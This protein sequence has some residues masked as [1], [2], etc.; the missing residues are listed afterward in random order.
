MAFDPERGDRAA[1]AAS[2]ADEGER[3]AA[4]LR[5]RPPRRAQRTAGGDLPAARAEAGPAAAGASRARSRSRSRRCRRAPPAR[6]G[7]D[8]PAARR[9]RRLPAAP[10]DQRPRLLRRRARASARSKWC[11]STRRAADRRQLHHR[12]SSS[13][14]ACSLTPPLARGLL[15]GV[16]R[17]ELID[18]G[19]AVERD[20]D[21]R[22]S[23]RRLPG[24]QCAARADARALLRLRKRHARSL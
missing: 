14:T 20:A 18:S 23:R 8:R 7:R 17:A 24:R 21:P 22:R 9:A 6:C 2:R 12:S 11:S 3:G 15:P 19:R 4:R 13:A 1:R 5:V 10:Q 16:L